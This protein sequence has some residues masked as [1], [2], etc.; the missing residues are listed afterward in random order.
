VGAAPRPALP[1][2]VRGQAA[3]AVFE[4]VGESVN[5]GRLSEVE[6]RLGGIQRRNDVAFCEDGT[7]VNL[8]VSRRHAHIDWDPEAGAHILYQD[9][10][11]SRVI[12]RVLRR[13]RWYSVGALGRGLLLQNGD[14]IHLGQAVLR[15]DEVAADNLAYKALP[16]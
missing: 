11:E 10:R 8:S 13:G 15:Y 16:Q 6:Q 9:R 7:P 14:E 1:T 3:Q 12:T 5:L 4:V 2:V